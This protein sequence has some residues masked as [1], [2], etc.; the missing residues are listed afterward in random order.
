VTNR[1][2]KEPVVRL[3]CVVCA[4]QLEIY[5]KVTKKCILGKT[6]PGLS[7]HKYETLPTSVSR[8]RRFA[9]NGAL[10]ASM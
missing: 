3:P 8:S 6:Y 7:K 10:A 4:G 9:N 5:A 2:T 1:K